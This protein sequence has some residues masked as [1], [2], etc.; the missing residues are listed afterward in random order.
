M[1]VSKDIHSSH[2]P[3]G[4]QAGPPSILTRSGTLK[5]ESSIGSED[6]LG[7]LP[8]RE[9]ETQKSDFTAKADNADNIF[10]EDIISAINFHFGETL[11]RARFVE[12]LWRFVR[13][14]S[15]YEEDILGA[16]TIGFPGV[17]F[18]EG[19]GDTSQLGSG[20]VFLDDVAGSREV[21]ANA[22]R[23]EGW[24][25]T[26]MH[27][28]FQEDFKRVRATSAIRG[29]DIHHQLWRLRN[30]KH[31]QDAEVELIMRTLVNA[32]QTYDQAVELLSLIPPYTGGLLPLSFGLFHQQEVVRDLTVD[33][34][35]QLRMFPVGVQFLQALNH[36]QRYAYVRQAHARESRGNNVRDPSGA[37]LLAPPTGFTRT[38][39]HRSELN[40]SA[41]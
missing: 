17:L 16:T 38:P 3:S 11:V 23:I 37:G 40:L 28:M 5:A 24:R 10:I 36:F 30:V 13:L 21:T 18:S 6:D 9:K 29:F 1:I 20:I 22:S 8:G 35:T 14:S 26:P 32:V 39:S 4:T 31:M 7:R 33:L 25:R 27:R 15:R 41:G 12:Y 2:P 19:P 34:F